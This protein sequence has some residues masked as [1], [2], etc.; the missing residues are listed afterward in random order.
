MTMEEASQIHYILAEIRV[1]Q[2]EL[3]KLQQDRNFYKPNII[4][5]MPKGG[6]STESDVDRHLEQEL[7]LPGHA[8]IQP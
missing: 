7:R 3:A 4:S 8:E 6:G 5:D 1:I 2:Q